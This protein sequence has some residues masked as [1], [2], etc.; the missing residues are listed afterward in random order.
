[1]A[2]TVIDMRKLL[3]FA[4][5]QQASDVLI[6]AGAPPMVRINGELIATKGEPLDPETSKKTVYSILTDDQIAR[7]EE[8]REL[9]FS[10]Y[11]KGLEQRFRGN[12]FL[13]RGC[14][15]AAFRLI[16]ERIPTRE[17]LE[18]PPVIEEFCNYHQGLIIVTGPTGHGK[19]TTQACMI[20]II[21]QRRRAHI[22]TIEDPIE[23]VHHN[24]NSIIEQREVGEDTHS[25]ASALR[26]VLRQD[27]NVILIGEMRDLE[28]MSAALTAAETGHLVI[29]TLHTNDAVQ[30][31]DR[32]LDAFPPHQQGQVRTQ[33][34]FCLLAVIAQR[35]VP[36]SDGKGRIVAVEILRNIPAVAHLI[37]EGKTHNIY[38]VMETHQREGMCTMDAALKKLYLRGLISR[39]EAR[40][41]MRNPE[42]LSRG[43][44]GPEA[45]ETRK[46]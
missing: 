6:T 42:Q 17:E 27:P 32:L 44:L 24:R 45:E 4:V 7:F 35:L 20:D 16:P 15:G 2:Q 1:M 43:A 25:F 8:K 39:E 46:R 26:H 30:S 12:A 23:Y 14:V 9:D 38:T 22:I 29:T 21:N 37:R 10:L 3:T 18:L 31:V 19:S 41:R 36:R 11:L 5:E 34:A 33:L 28:T 40:T 13:Q